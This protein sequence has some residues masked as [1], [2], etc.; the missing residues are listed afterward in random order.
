MK[1]SCNVSLFMTYA[2]GEV[3]VLIHCLHCT[4]CWY[5]APLF[6]NAGIRGRSVA[7]I[8]IPHEIGDVYEHT[9]ESYP[10]SDSTASTFRCESEHDMSPV[11]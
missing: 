1:S 7:F 11:L 6:R 3:S 8:L 10:H 9:C 5:C 2:Y 4:H